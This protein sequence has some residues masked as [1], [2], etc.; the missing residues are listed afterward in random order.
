MFV[1]NFI[2]WWWNWCLL[3]PYLFTIFHCCHVVSKK[4]RWQLIKCLIFSF[5]SEPGSYINWIVFCVNSNNVTK[6]DAGMRCVF[7][8]HGSSLSHT[9]THRTCL[10]LFFKKTCVVFS[11]YSFSPSLIHPQV[12]SLNLESHQF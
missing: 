11:Y 12:G 2:I 7:L 10:L 5:T 4:T 3:S 9:T 6:P 8:G 1:L